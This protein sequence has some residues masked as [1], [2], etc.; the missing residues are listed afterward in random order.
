MSKTTKPNKVKAPKE[1]TNVPA[2]PAEVAPEVDEAEADADDLDSGDE[3]ETGD[4]VTVQYHDPLKGVTSRVF[5]RELHGEKFRETAKIFCET[6]N[7]QSR[8][9]EIIK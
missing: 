4:T 2:S 7:S 8:S 6:Q 1:E 9:A 5:T 3:E